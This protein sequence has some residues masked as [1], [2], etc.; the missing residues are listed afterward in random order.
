MQTK[1]KFIYAVVVLILEVV[2]KAIS[3]FTRRSWEIPNLPPN[4]GFFCITLV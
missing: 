4:Q 1:P 3:Q 2:S